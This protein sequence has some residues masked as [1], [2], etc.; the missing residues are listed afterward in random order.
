MLDRYL[1]ACTIGNKIVLDLGLRV[2]RETVAKLVPQVEDKAVG[3][4][5]LVAILGHIEVIFTVAAKAK[6]AGVV[7]SC[8]AVLEV[9]QVEEEH[10]DLLLELGVRGRVVLGEDGGST[11]EQEGCGEGKAEGHSR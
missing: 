2:Q 6:A 5:L 8:L 11:G 7:G 3:V 9:N 1:A 4:R 10:L